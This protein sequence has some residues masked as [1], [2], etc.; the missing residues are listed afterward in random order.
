MYL[1]FEKLKISSKKFTC[2]QK[3]KSKMQIMFFETKMQQ[4]KCR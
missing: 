4:D 1:A 3:T 2:G